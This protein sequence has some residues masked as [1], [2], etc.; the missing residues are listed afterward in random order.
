M[1]YQRHSSLP[2]LAS[3]PASQPRALLAAELVR[4][5]DLLVPHDLAAVAVDGD[6][7]P[8]GEIVDD[9]VFPQ[10]D[11]AALRDVALVLDA[12]VGDPHELAVVAGAHIDLVDRAPTVGR[13]HEAIVDQRIDFVLGAVLPDVL[14]AAERHRPHHAQILDVVAIDLGEL[15]VA[16]RAVVAIHHQPV[17]RLT[18]GVDQAVLVDRHLVL[19]RER[20]RAQGDERHAQQDSARTVGDTSAKTHEILPTGFLQQLSGAVD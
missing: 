6:D 19:D 16:G 9:E 1:A 7:A 15:R 14:H 3:S 20:R 2:V 4:L 13:V 11:A 12:G 17:L 5:C 8:V 18:V 10:C